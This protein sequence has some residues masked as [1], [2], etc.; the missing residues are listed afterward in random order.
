MT[1]NETG[2]YSLDGSFQSQGDLRRKHILEWDS[3]AFIVSRTAF[4]PERDFDTWTEVISRQQDERH[5]LL[6]IPEA[7][8]VTIQTGR[9]ILLTLV[10]DVHAGSNEV[11]YRAFANDVKLTRSVGGFSL[12]FGD[13]TDSYFFFPEAGEQI[14]S[15]DEQVLFMQSALKQLSE[16]GHLIAAWG[17]DHDM[18]ARDRSGAHT[19]YQNFQKNYQ[20]HYL[21][22][23]SYV[24]VNLYDGKQTTPYQIVGSHRHKGFSVYNDSHA[25]WRQQLDESNMNGD[26]VSVTAHNHVKG[27][28]RQ[29]RKTF[30]GKD[31]TIHAISLGTYKESDRYS[32]KMGWARTG[33]QGI[34]ATALILYPGK[35][36]IEFYWTVEEA[37]NSLK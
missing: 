33:E 31:R 6:G 24:T 8:E 21:E 4:P 34:G 14:V 10:G 2:L 32:R 9:P 17:G 19:L 3:G 15:G 18:W 36:K 27:Y 25:S 12:A 26:V 5:E 16:N 1:E 35:Q 30:G 29:V 20:T 37:V 7:I 22:G 28:L 23:V 13:L 11:N